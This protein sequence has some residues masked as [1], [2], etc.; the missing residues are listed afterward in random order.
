MRH[1]PVLIWYHQCRTVVGVV[2]EHS[3]TQ[4][5]QLQP[6]SPPLLPS[7]V[8]LPIFPP[9]SWGLSVQGKVF[10]EEGAYSTWQWGGVSAFSQPQL[11]V[12]S[13]QC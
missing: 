8:S 12:F 3:F 6:S 4:S 1:I 13:Q 7:P 10:V 5:Q 2:I 11:P 9:P